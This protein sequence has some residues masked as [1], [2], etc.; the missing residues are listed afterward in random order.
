MRP[1][2]AILVTANFQSIKREF[3]IEDASEE[4]AE[5]SKS[6]GLLVTKNLIFRQK[7]PNAALFIGTGKAQELKEL[8]KK[9]KADLVVFEGNLSSTQQRNLEEILQAKTIDRT[10]LILDIF[11]QRA[12]SMEGK[13][14]VELAQI[15]YLLPRLAGK[16]IALS[17]LGGGVGTRGPGEQKLEMDRRR[18]RERIAKLTQ[19]LHQI[20]KRRLANIQKK[21]EKDLPLIALVGYTNAGKSSLFNALTQASMLVKDKLFST[22]D[23]TTRLLN[24]PGN[25][26]ALISDT[27]GFVRELPH[28]L[29][30]SFKATL[31]EAVYADVLIHVIDASRPDILALEKAVLQVLRELGADE[32][33]TILVLNKADLVDDDK[34]ER[35]ILDA[36]WSGGVWTSSLKGEGL[37]ILL[38]RILKN[39]TTEYYQKDFFISRERLDLLH[40]F[41][42]EAEVLDRRDEA[43]GVFLSVRLSLKKEVRFEQKLA[44]GNEG[45]RTA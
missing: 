35:M 26:K 7:I 5:L 19:E 32:K 21:K 18:I 4:L 20:E 3:G 42:E 23:T 37:D 30:E 31:E 17:R 15:K 16:G 24:L 8:V 33:R 9:E 44:S 43:D 22:L 28:H 36:H 2:Q 29:I 13:L 25:R 40:F 41:Y 1:E 12:R 38:S 34:K 14:Q 45:F 27:V 39:F 11:A 6:A 10:Q